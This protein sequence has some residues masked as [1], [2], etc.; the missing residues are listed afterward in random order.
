M[1]ALVVDDDAR[2][3]HALSDE[4]RTQLDHHRVLETDCNLDAS[5]VLKE[6]RPDVLFVDLS[7]AGRIDLQSCRVLPPAVVILSASDQDAVRDLRVAGISAWMKPE[8]FSH[9]PEILLWAETL[10]GQPDCICEQWALT[11]LQLGHRSAKDSPQVLAMSG[12]GQMLVDG[13]EILGAS[14]IGYLTRIVLGDRIVRSPHR[15]DFLAKQL[16]G[17]GFVRVG[18]HLLIRRAH[19]WRMIAASIKLSLRNLFRR[20]SRGV[21][22]TLP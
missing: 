14:S 11:L 4:I 16:H 22:P 10:R 3:R 6:L 18:K 12:E 7:C 17:C 15:L 8:V 19:F 13:R 2:G 5:R 21:S 20:Q 1:L 9:L